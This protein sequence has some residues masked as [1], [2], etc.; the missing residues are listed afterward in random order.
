MYV[1]SGN[2]ATYLVPVLGN[3]VISEGVRRV[4]V[5]G[6]MLTKLLIQS[7]SMKQVKMQEH[8]IAADFIKQQMCFVSDD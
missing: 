1:E 8:Y 2:G 7:I 6:K 5:G 4:D 3:S